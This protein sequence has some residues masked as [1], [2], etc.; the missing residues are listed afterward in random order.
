MAPGAGRS[1]LQGEERK[2][3]R[4]INSLLVLDLLQVGSALLSGE[5]NTLLPDALLAF[6]QILGLCQ[7]S[8][9]SVWVASKLTHPNPKD[10]G[11]RV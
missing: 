11:K 1:L 9:D 6:D 2:Y 4:G 10:T 8:L 7:V 3:V 5:Q